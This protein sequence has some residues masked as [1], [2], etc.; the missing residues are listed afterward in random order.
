M[1]KT[2]HWWSSDA[3]G[4]TGIEVMDTVRA[5]ICYRPLRICWAISAGDFAAFRSAVRTTFTMWGGRFNPIAIV[6]RPEEA[7]RIVPVGTTDALDAFK[8]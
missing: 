6:D 3:P 4:E 7:D 8:K 1:Q 5:N 2:N